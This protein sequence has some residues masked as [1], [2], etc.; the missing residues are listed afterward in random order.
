MKHIAIDM[1]GKRIGRLS[2]VERHG[3]DKKGQ[4]LFKCICDCGNETIT[5]GY[6]LRKGI[7]QYCV[8][9]QREHAGKAHSRDLTG[10][11]IGNIIVLGPVG[12]RE[13]KNGRTK[14]YRIRCDCGNEKDVVQSLLTRKNPIKSCGCMTSDLITQ[15]N[16]IDITGQHFGRL[17]AMRPQRTVGG[18]Y[19]WL[20]KCMCG[21]EIVT[22]LT[23]LRDG[24]TTSCGCYHEEICR[25]DIS[26]QKFGMLTAVDIAYTNKNNVYWNCVCEC[27][28]YCVVNG[29]SMREGR[30]ISC[31]CLRSV[32]ENLIKCFLDEHHICYYREKKFNACKD[33]GQ[34]KFDFWLPDYGICIE[35]DGQQHFESV[36]I[37]GDEHSLED[38]QRRDAI[39][40]KYCEE[41]DIILLRIPYWEK[42]NIES[43]LSDWLF[44]YDNK[45]AGDTE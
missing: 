18:H 43:I 9:L 15:K 3:T 11:R 19:G 31:G 21:N 24:H 44:L 26:G 8:C 20:C 28:G 14:T 25:K 23:K 36:A 1:V 6:N 27:G 12:Y 13:Y 45:G 33:L 4:A 42:D 2:V 39:K 16:T 41:N 30:T 34:L 38:R 37:W 10:M 40:S 29:S 7:T 35:F 32:G 5:T 22:T 17:T